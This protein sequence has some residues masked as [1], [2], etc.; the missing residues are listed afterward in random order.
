MS[1]WK[2]IVAATPPAELTGRWVTKLAKLA[3]QRAGEGG[4]GGGDG[5]KEKPAPVR[6]SAKSRRTHALAAL[7]RLEF[8][9]RNLSRCYSGRLIGARTAK[10]T[11]VS[12]LDNCL[13]WH[14]A[15]LGL[16]RPADGQSV[17]GSG[18]LR[19]AYPICRPAGGRRESPDDLWGLYS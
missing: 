5:L 6:E 2:E 18:S 17:P 14:S 10:T 16:P 4:D 19:K 11:H 9:V 1:C 13:M 8:S 3:K 15:S 7:R 12:Y